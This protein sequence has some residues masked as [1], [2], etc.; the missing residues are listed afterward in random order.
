[1]TGIKEIP[2]HPRQARTGS[3][4]DKLWVDCFATLAMTCKV[5]QHERLRSYWITAAVMPRRGMTS[6]SKAAEMIEQNLAH[7]LL[8]IK[9]DLLTINFF[10]LYYMH[11]PIVESVCHKRKRPGRFL[12]RPFSA[13]KLFL[14]VQI[15]IQQHLQKTLQ[16]RRP[17]QKS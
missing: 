15:P 7:L 9:F 16:S 17:R 1:M 4:N 3:G 2:G 12:S 5:I 6:E 8:K 10:H 13:H 14:P 11:T